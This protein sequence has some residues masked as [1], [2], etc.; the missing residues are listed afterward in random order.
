MVLPTIET[1]ALVADGENLLQRQHHLYVKTN[2]V[3]WALGVTNLAAEVDIAPH[4]SFSLPVYWSSWNYLK[5]TLKIRTL[6]VQP[7]VRYWLAE[8]NEG[9]FA[10]AHL[11][12]ASYNF[13]T[14]GDYRIQDHDGHSP[15]FGGG[16]VAGYRMPLFRNTQ[17]LIDF[18][19]GAGVYR[20][21][22]D[23]FHNKENGLL[24]ET[25]Q[26]TWFGIDQ[27]AVSIAYTFDWGK[28]G[29]TR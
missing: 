2:S 20:L 10:G 23:K 22:Y 18:S 13:A 1:A 16:V 7:E 8:S 17:W 4:W 9:W 5:Q 29:G 19:L 14:G 3:G 27:V 26:K 21:H 15:A 28:K 11:G 6:A 25:K 24:V 12:M